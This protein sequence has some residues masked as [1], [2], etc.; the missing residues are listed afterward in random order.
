M[1]IHFYDS[2]FNPKI[3]YGNS[4]SQIISALQAK[5]YGALG[6][7]TGTAISAMTTLI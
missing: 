5:I 4:K 7:A 6:T 2:N 3:S 1:S